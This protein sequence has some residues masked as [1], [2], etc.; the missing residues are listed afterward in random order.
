MSG[1]YGIYRYDGAPVAGDCLER[2]RSAMAYYGPHGGGSKIEGPLAMGHML[3]EID[4]EDRYEK[5][6]V[7]G[8]R[9][10]IVSAARLDNRDDL[11]EAFQIPADSRDKTPDGHLVSLAFDRWGEGLATH[12]QGDW[13]LAGWDRREC[14]LLLARD[15]FGSGALYFH[16]GK[17]F[18]AFAS[19]LKA[20][21]AIPGVAREPDPLRLAEVLVSWQH[22][23]GLTAYK[24]FHR[25][26]WAHSLTVKTDGH[27]LR[28][29]YWSPEGRDL[30]RYRRDE[31][32]EDAFLEHYTRAVQGCLRTGKPVASQLSGGRDSGSV[33]SIA[34][35]LLAGQGR[36]LTAYTSVPCFPPDGARKS[37]E[38]NEWDR[39]H[40]T[41]MLAGPN[42]RHVA[43][44][45]AGYG[46]IQAIEHHLLV[47]DG[48]SHAAGNHFW[49]QAIT[50]LAARS[51]AGVL[52]T[53]Q[54]GNGTVS[55][56]GNG[57]AL[58]ALLQRRPRLAWQLFLH[59]DAKPWRALKRQI[60]RPAVTPIRRW[61]RRQRSPDSQPWRAYSALNPT[62]ATELDIDGRMRTAGYDPTFTFAP[63]E[64]L[65]LRFFGPD[66][67]VGGDLW[68]E[69]G[70]MHALS[71]R[72]PTCN[73]A[74]IEFLLRVPDTQYY[75]QGEGSSLLRRT[76]RDR[77]PEEVLNG[78]RKGLQSADLGHRVLNEL[79]AM[80]RCL[81]AFEGNPAASEF[82]DMPLLRKCLEDLV[83][84]VDPD[85]TRAAG[86]ILLRGLGVGLF[87][88]RF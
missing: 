88:C 29:C 43:V 60:L 20:L 45:A 42:V 86:S 83:K 6:P 65:R 56:T 80:R 7:E 13:A 1:I 38:G 47:H 30:L 57:S 59:A 41:A 71:V 15:A 2:M 55:W 23:A 52:L 36:E 10:L 11:L 46:V 68:S 9:G 8:R 82:L 28:R 48:P 79:P 58:L 19:S 72:D 25:L 70:A 4:P 44:D 37:R 85:T 53:G 62:M 67:T 69:I 81:D 33:T 39:A 34:A 5:Q 49:I 22:D 63:Q 87:L 16:E 35:Q 21:L 78:S 75:R 64:D 54:M 3:L 84:S 24:S 40:G 32:Y 61:V 66:R 27:T 26:V 31:D 14:K 76:F 77:I 51:G 12:L 74:M 17:G 50:E 73:L 18:V